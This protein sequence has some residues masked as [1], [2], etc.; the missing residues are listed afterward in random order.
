MHALIGTELSILRDRELRE[1]AARGRPVP[2]PRRPTPPPPI[3]R[4]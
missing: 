1:R 4:S 2:L 3:D